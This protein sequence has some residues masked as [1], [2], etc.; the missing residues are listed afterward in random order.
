MSK[1]LT[2]IVY[3]INLEELDRL[4][5]HTND[6]AIV[7]RILAEAR[8][9]SGTDEELY[10]KL[11]SEGLEQSSV[12]S[13]QSFVKA[14]HANSYAPGKVGGGKAAIVLPPHH[15]AITLSYEFSERLSEVKDLGAK[16]S[17]ALKAEGKNNLPDGMMKGDHTSKLASAFVLS[18]EN[19]DY[20]SSFSCFESV[21]MNRGQ[22]SER[23]KPNAPASITILYEGGHPTTFASGVKSDYPYDVAP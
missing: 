18:A 22:I 1:N 8:Y 11:V 13:D 16:L 7:L 5:E 12:E 21:V 3:Q 17:D 9:Q 23:D 6:V 10:T 15:A 14:V 20:G 2:S 4:E 19:C